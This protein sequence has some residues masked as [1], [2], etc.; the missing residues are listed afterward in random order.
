MLHLPQYG[1]HY[2]AT[3]LKIFFRPCGY[4]SKVSSEANVE[5]RGEERPE[6]ELATNGAGREGAQNRG[7]DKCVLSLS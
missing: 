7:T 2:Y 3:V 5:A 1:T 6:V 4:F